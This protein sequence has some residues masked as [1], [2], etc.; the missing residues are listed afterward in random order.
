M[1]VAF[2]V[3][4]ALFSARPALAQ[5]RD[6]SKVEV[7]TEA[8]RGNVSVLF[9]QGGNIGV[10]AAPDGVLLV[11][12]QFAP[13][14][15]KILAAVKA[16]SP[17][18]IR[19]VLNTHWHGDHV[20]GNENMGKAGV[21][22]VAQD[23][24]RKRM[25]EGMD[26]PNRKA[27]PAP[28]AALPIVTFAQDETIHLG[29][30]TVR[31]MHVENAHTDGDVIVRFEKANV[32]HMGDTFFNGRYPIIDLDSGGSIAGMIAA[33]DRAAPWIDA[34]TKVVPGHGPVSD[35]AGL[36]E[37]QAMLA[38]IKD[39]IGKQVK[40]KKTLAEIQAMK[41][42]QPYDAKWGNGG[43]KPDRFVEDVYTDL[44]R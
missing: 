43:T 34:D 16:L 9:G 33:V 14:T 39:A 22:I 36:K 25:A 31:V 6:W 3:L 40:A 38:A 28:A 19:L 8:L 26:T 13:L 29:G 41:P 4:A 27:P 24:V 11:D 21:V 12:D 2:V 1:L 30:E 35:L 15:P 23:N 10:L 42:T 44:S 37:Y 18:P 20:G 7:K 17:A 5:D 32:V